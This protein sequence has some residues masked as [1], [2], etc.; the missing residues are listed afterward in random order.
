MCTE[1]ER[2]HTVVSPALVPSDIWEILHESHS[3][4]LQG[5][6]PAQEEPEPPAGVGDMD[7]VSGSTGSSLSRLD[8]HAI[9]DMVASVEDMSLSVH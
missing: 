7:S 9:E 5:L 2:E 1:Y 8:W 6:S 4:L 3:S